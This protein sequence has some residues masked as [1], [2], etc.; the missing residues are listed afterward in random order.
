MTRRSILAAVV[1]MACTWPLAGCSGSK[2]PAAA[3]A[4]NGTATGTAR[5]Q[6]SPKGIP[7]RLARAKE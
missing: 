2:P 1:V 5:A 4:V 7:G 6:P 3:D